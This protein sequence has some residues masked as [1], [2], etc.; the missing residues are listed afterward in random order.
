VNSVLTNAS[1]NSPKIPVQSLLQDAWEIL[2]DNSMSGVANLPDPDAVLDSLLSL[3]PEDQSQDNSGQT[4]EL[5]TGDVIFDFTFHRA[6]LFSIVNGFAGLRN[7]P[8]GSI[9]RMLRKQHQMSSRLFDI[10]RS[11]PHIFAK[12]LADNLF[13]AAVE[14]CDEQAVILILQATRNW[15]NSIIPN[16]IACKFGSDSRLYTPIELAAKFR[17]LGIVRTL[18]AA[19]ADV[20]QQDI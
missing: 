6:L 13:R 16:D 17:H 4:V 1:Q 3:L 11:C 5:T 12:S 2:R 14:A 19:N 18:L 20:N 10:L 8:S 7:V 15:P 9:L